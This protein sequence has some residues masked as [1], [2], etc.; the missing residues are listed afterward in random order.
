MEICRPLMYEAG[1]SL[2]P[3]PDGTPAFFLTLTL[4]CHLGVNTVRGNTP[5]FSS[6][7]L[8]FPVTPQPCWMIRI[9]IMMMRV[10]LGLER[11]MGPHPP[12]CLTFTSLESIIPANTLIMAGPDGGGPRPLTVQVS[13]E[14][15]E[16][17]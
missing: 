2:V 15:V 8:I 14:E 5:H 13:V 6:C 10:A 9:M 16:W 17:T 12:S 1:A 4:Q 7:W 3:R 11:Q